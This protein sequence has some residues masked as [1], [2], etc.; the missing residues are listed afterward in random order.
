MWIGDCNG[1]PAMRKLVD[2]LKHFFHP[3][4]RSRGTADARCP[5]T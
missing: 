3:H 4:A 2:H 5:L 1:L